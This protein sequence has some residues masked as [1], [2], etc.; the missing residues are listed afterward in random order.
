[1]PGDQA[2]FAASSIHN[3][4]LKMGRFNKVEPCAL[5]SKNVGGFLSH[6]YKCQSRKPIAVSS[7]WFISLTVSF[8]ACKLSFHK[9]CNQ[10]ACKF[11]C[12]PQTSSPQSPVRQ[13][14]WEPLVSKKQS[15]QHSTVAELMSALNH[16]Q[17]L[18]PQSSKWSLTRTSQFTDPADQVV[19]CTED[20]RQMNIFIFKKVRNFYMSCLV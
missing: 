2:S 7:R 16:Q 17:P 11:P 4:T 3:H 12:Q 6:G 13:R 9:E 1:M 19:G 20:L 10:F 15:R 5:C 8:V 14:P 18:S